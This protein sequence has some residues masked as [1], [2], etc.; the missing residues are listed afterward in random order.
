MNVQDR[1]FFNYK[2]AVE[3]YLRMGF[4]FAEDKRLVLNNMEVKILKMGSDI[5]RTTIDYKYK[6]NP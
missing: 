3:T 5:W 4:E 2:E 6:T 1:M